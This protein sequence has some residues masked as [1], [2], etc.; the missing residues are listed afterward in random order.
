MEGVEM[1]RWGWGR[2]GKQAAMSHREDKGHLGPGGWDRRGL[3]D[4][5]PLL[6]NIGF[7][8]V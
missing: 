4:G 6:A 2:R 5:L 1:R 7:G 8:G 3:V